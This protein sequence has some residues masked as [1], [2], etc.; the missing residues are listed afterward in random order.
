MLELQYVVCVL[1]SRKMAPH[2]RYSCWE[3]SW[4]EDWW[5]DPWDLKK[6]WT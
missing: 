4:T 6:N 5:A 2:P 1:L 3:I